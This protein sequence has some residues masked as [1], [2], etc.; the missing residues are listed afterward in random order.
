MAESRPFPG[1]SGALRQWQ[2]DAI[3]WGSLDGDGPR[4]DDAKGNTSMTSKSKALR[5]LAPGDVIV[6]DRGG[7]TA[8]V[9]SNQ[10][11]SWRAGY[12]DTYFLMDGDVREGIVVAALHA[13]GM[14]DGDARAVVNIAVDAGLVARRGGFAIVLTAAGRDMARFVDEQAAA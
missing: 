5:D 4:A 13:A 2:R 8:K 14:C 6:I 11:A 9:I 10:A 12:F 7:H 1:P 3:V